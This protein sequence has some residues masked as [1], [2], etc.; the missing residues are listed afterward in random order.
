[1]ILEILLAVV[2]MIVIAITFYIMVVQPRNRK[3]RLRALLNASNG[4]FDEPARDALKE[5]NETIEGNKVPTPAQLAARGRLVRYNILDGQVRGHTRAQ[6]V[7][8]GQAVQDYDRAVRGL[9]QQVMDQD[10]DR[11]ST[12]LN[13]SHVD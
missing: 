6:R 12:R 11:K 10:I 8:F 13:S 2:I 5:L 9:R 7:Q 4:T 1:M 3:H